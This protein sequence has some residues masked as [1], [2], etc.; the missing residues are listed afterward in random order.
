M[1]KLN[2]MAET[3]LDQ[4]TSLDQKKAEV[5]ST[6]G[7]ASSSVTRAKMETL[8][9]RIGK[10]PLSKEKQEELREAHAQQ[11]KKTP[12]DNNLWFF[13]VSSALSITFETF[14]SANF[15]NSFLFSLLSSCSF[16]TTSFQA[17]SPLL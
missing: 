5:D 4:E 8:D 6:V 2:T 15:G 10:K 11:L 3:L 9:I 17:G 13:W 16:S 7:E 14:S 1:K 12:K